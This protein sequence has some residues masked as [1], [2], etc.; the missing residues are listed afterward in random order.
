MAAV[1]AEMFVALEQGAVGQGWGVAIVELVRIRVRAARRQNR[2]DGNFRLEAGQG[3]RA[4][5]ESIQL[6]AK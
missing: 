3:I 1:Q 4:A 6:L 2:V 5:V